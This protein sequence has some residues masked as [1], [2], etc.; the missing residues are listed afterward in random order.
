MPGP[1]DN[2]Q[3][4]RRIA[5]LAS[6]P[7]PPLIRTAP[8][9][10]AKSASPRPP[11]KSVLLPPIN[12]HRG[13]YW[14]TEAASK[15]DGANTGARERRGILPPRDSGPLGAQGWREE[16]LVCAA[17]SEATTGRGGGVGFPGAPLHQQPFKCRWRSGLEAGLPGAGEQAMVP[18]LAR[19]GQA[20]S[21]QQDATVPRCPESALLRGGA[22]G[23]S[24]PPALSDSACA[25]SFAKYLTN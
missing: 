23:S 17:Q 10:G 22:G 20:S 25:S 2:A 5:V 9:A 4:L 19:L 11:P 3:A 24:A 7:P 13:C 18:A 12:A 8:H 15:A 21:T 1:S 16:P 14:T 6:M